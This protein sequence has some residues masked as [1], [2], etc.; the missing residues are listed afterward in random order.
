MRADGAKTWVFLMIF[1]VPHR[2]IFLITKRKLVKMHGLMN[3]TLSPLGTGMEMLEWERLGRSVRLCL[4]ERVRCDGGTTH[5]YNLPL[6]ALKVEVE[7]RGENGHRSRAKKE[8]S[9]RP[10]KG[11]V[12]I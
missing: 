1:L 9:G 7:E 8:K 12:L 2:N 11:N 5:R 3:S 10:G 4:L 6:Q